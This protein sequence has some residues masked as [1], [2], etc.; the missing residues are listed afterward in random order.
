[1]PGSPVRFRRVG[2]VEAAGGQRIEN[3]YRREA[4]EKGAKQDRQQELPGRDAG[5]AHDDE[6]VFP[7]ERY[8]RRHGRE[9]RDE[10]HGLLQDE[11]HAHRRDRQRGQHRIVWQH[12]RPSRD[13]CEIDDEAEHE[14]A[15]QEIG[16]DGQVADHEIAPESAADYH[17][18]CSL[19]R[20]RGP[21]A[22]R[23]GVDIEETAV[24]ALE[25]SR[26]D[27]RRGRPS[28]RLAA[29]R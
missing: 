20:R 2:E 1:M 8:Q 24:R 16:R 22:A 11:R 26:A 3:E 5:R 29:I 19:R 23:E 7:V 15:E 13:L 12:R 18:F 27:N 21:G 4:E 28:L 6:F 10:G 17:R 9:K 14:D 25:S